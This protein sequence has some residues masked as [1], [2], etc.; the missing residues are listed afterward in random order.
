MIRQSILRTIIGAVAVALAAG[1]AACGP[2]PIDP[3]LPFTPSPVASSRAIPPS[4]NT[5]ASEGA[6]PIDIPLTALLQSAD[7]GNGFPN[8]Q[9]HCCSDGTLGW[10]LAHCSAGTPDPSLARVAMRT[11]TFDYG[12]T[13][14]VYQMAYRYQAGQAQQEFAWY[15]GKVAACASLDVGG[16]TTL[17]VLAESFAG[18]AS[19]LVQEKRGGDRYLFVLVRVGDLLTE[20]SATPA[21]DAYSRQL[22]QKAAPRLCIATAC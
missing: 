8:D 7:A 18:S 21:D 4:S 14:F 1:A 13:R 2:T 3:G 9:P 10:V 11:R 15:A 5:P 19:M 20:I 16:P 22:G 17:T 12:D 6:V